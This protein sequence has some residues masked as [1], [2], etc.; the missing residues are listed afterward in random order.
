[1]IGS[2]T[3]VPNTPGLVIVKVP[4]CTSSGDSFLERARSARSLMAA[5]GAEQVELVGAADHRH[6]EPPVERHRDAEV[7]VPPVERALAHDGRVEHRMLA[8][9]LRHRRRR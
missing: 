7:D 8:Q 6:D 4:F 3:S 2:P 5:R 9:G 1:M